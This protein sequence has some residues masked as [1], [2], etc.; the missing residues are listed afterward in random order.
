LTATGGSRPGT[1]HE[2]S[3]AGTSGPLLNQRAVA[4]SMLAAT[5]WN[6]TASSANSVTGSA[7][8]SIRRSGSIECRCV[9][10]RASVTARSRTFSAKA[11]RSTSLR[12]N[13]PSRSAAP[14]GSAA[15]KTPLMAPIEVPMTRSGWMPASSSASSMPTS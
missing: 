3:T 4:D 5:H 9:P 12:Q 6:G 2:A 8:V 1:A 7:S 15:T 14:F 11:S 10:D 13:W